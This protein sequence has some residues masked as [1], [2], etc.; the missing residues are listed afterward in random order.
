MTMK[1]SNYRIRELDGRLW[2]NRTEAGI[3]LTRVLAPAATP[4]GV[5]AG[6][7]CRHKTASVYA[8]RSFWDSEPLRVLAVVRIMGR[9]YVQL[10]SDREVCNCTACCFPSLF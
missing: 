1:S 2:Q 5:F 8:L 6:F 10:S 4:A 7:D 3:I 9:K